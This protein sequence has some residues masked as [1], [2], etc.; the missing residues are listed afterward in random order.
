MT[1]TPTDV[2]SS[3]EDESQQSLSHR[4]AQKLKHIFLYPIQSLYKWFLW[5][6]INQT[7]KPKH[8][9]IILDGNRRYARAQGL[10][11][12]A[13]HELGA[14][15]VE[16]VLAYCWEL[17]IRTITL[18]AFSIENFERPKP[19]VDRIMKLAQQ[20]FKELSTH[21][22]IFKYKVRVR[23]IGRKELLP[24]EVREAIAEVEEKT[25]QFDDY[26]LNVAIAYSGRAEIVDAVRTLLQ[27]KT[28]TEIDEA[29]FE[30]YLY[31]AGQ[32]DP[33]LIIRTS[34][35]YRISGFLLWQAAYSEL[36]FSEKYW[37]EMSKID[38]WRA[39]HDYQ[40]RHRRFGR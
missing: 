5:R 17:G 21:P 31:T 37:P 38:L 10:E 18:Y 12:W 28:R 36:Y 26:H 16:E 33:D 4:I 29:T 34:G 15:K 35:E 7:E 30:H 1:E 3:D 2:I 25:K 22:L 8:V 20:K 9:G 6:K 32:P 19:E 11:I 24:I 27:D 13:G 40:K 23:A 39:V 14:K